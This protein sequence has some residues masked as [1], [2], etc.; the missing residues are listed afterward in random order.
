MRLLGTPGTR[1]AAEGGLVRGLRLQQ[2]RLYAS[3]SERT[4]SGDEQLQLRLFNE[5]EA[6][7]QPEAEERTLETITYQRKKRRESREERWKDLPVERV[8]HRLSEQEQVCP[9]SHGHLHEMGFDVRR[10]LM[11]IPAQVKVVEHVQ[12]KYAC[13]DC[14]HN[15]I[16]TPI[17][18]AQMPRPVQPGSMASPSAVAYVMTKKFVE[19]MPLYRQEQQFTRNGVQLSRQTLAN[20]VVHA[21][22]T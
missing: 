20:W 5:A 2:K 15:D 1:A 6:E 21:S 12:Y 18:K 22:T 7:A 19:G 4:H 16:Q 9:Q 14:D 11:I 10:E 17:V 13:R 8:E 3:S